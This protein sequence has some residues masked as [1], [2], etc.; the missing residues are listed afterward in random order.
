MRAF[1]RPIT[2]VQ[3]LFLLRGINIYFIDFARV[4]ASFR[5]IVSK[6]STAIQIGTTSLVTLERN[7]ILNK[8]SSQKKYF[9]YCSLNLKKGNK[10][11][12][13]KIKGLNTTEFMIFFEKKM[14][15]SEK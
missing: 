15:L 13:M 9:K 3:F 4:Q 1:L 5:A 11:R 14:S 8:N 7:N 6:L 12:E 2:F 10:F